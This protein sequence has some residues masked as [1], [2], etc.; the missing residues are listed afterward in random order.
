MKKF[1]FSTFQLFQIL[2]PYEFCLWFRRKKKEIRSYWISSRFK[3][4]PFSV[5]F[6]SIA[7]LRGTSHIFIG[8]NSNFDDNLH[9]MAWEGFGKQSFSPEIEIG[10]NCSF[11]AYN[12]ITCCKKITIGDGTLTG[13][14][15]T[16]SD[17]N[18]GSYDVNDSESLLEWG[19]VRPS[20]RTIS[21][22]G[23]IEIGKNVWIGD[24]ATIL[25]GVSIGDGAVIGANSVVTKDV[26]AYS[27]VGGNPAKVLKQ[28]NKQSIK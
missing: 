24:K 19:D 9:L 21:I 28:L 17:N 14:W 10:M 13:K 16:I 22:K 25:S 23:P 27:I 26:P 20:L 8:E 4:C 1:L 2:Y 5:R 3:N 7:S 6:G 12:H 15:V 11:G 18:H